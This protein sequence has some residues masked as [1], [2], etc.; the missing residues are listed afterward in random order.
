MA[1]TLTNGQQVEDW[2]VFFRRR[3][4][5]GSSWDIV[6][7]LELVQLDDNLPVLAATLTVDGNPYT[8]PAGASYTIRVRRPYGTAVQ[9]DALGVDAD[10]VAYIEF[11][12]ALTSIAGTGCA[13]IEVSLPD[14]SAKCTQIF[15]LHIAHNPIPGG[16]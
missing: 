2:R 7:P 13:A 4:A 5:L 3:L 12:P 9:A 16:D 1:I 11:A 14:G 15:R 6:Q 8:A 10:G